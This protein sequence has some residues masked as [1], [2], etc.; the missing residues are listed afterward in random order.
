MTRPRKKTRPLPARR[1][2]EAGLTGGEIPRR[3]ARTADGVTADDAA[4]ATMI[5]ETGGGDPADV[6]GP[7]PADAAMSIVS[8]DSIGAGVGLDEAEQARLDPITP[9]ELKRIRQRVARSR[10]R[11]R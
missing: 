9:D 11:R 7:Q 5:D 3:G 10:R 1:V 4:P 2:R 8:A 6:R